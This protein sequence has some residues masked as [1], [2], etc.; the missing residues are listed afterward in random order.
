[1][2]SVDTGKEKVKKICEVLREETIVPA[3]KQG[4][5]I[6]AKARADAE[7]IIEAAKSEASKM[8]KEAERKIEEKK[9]VFQASMNLA[10]KKSL[11]TLKETIE[12]RLFD[13]QLSELIGE[14]TRDPKVVTQLIQALV[15]GIEKEG[16]EG[17][18]RA[19]VS[20]AIDIDALNKELTSQVIKRLKSQSIEVGEIKGGAQIKIVDQNITIDLSDEALKELL[21]RF[22]R[23]DFRS[24]IF[25]ATL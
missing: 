10:A 7:K 3:K 8:I 12:K 11:D 2:K 13:P 24:L 25:Q 1:M 17:D 4:D 9:N 19:I 22:V 23:D 16:I 15:V 21:A 6:V 18:L 20:R 5:Q 14:K